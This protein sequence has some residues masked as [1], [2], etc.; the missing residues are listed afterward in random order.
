MGVIVPAILPKD[1]ADLEDKLYKLHGIVD[2]VQ[3]DV[4]DGRFASPASWPYRDAAG[5]I[6]ARSDDALPYLGELAYEFDLMVDDPEKVIGHW[7]QAGAN[8][9]TVHAESTHRLPQILEDLK[10][11]YG[12]DKDFAPDLLSFG[13][14][15]NTTTDLALIDPYIEHCDYVQFMGISTIGKQGQPFDKRVI[16]KIAEFRKKHSDILIQVDGAVSLE[17]APSLLAAGVSRLV[18]GSALWKSPNLREE[19]RKFKAIAQSYGMYA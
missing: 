3:V 10:V 17:T 5:R 12:Y 11:K 2:C 6:P 19:I 14:A 1:R 13:L 7:V 8:R 16:A 18:I 4:V 9:I 15:I